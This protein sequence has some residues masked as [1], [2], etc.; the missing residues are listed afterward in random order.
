MTNIHDQ[1][2]I[3]SLGHTYGMPIHVFVVQISSAPA[4]PSQ[5]TV[6]KTQVNL[7][8]QWLHGHLYLSYRYSFYP[9]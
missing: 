4:E 3:Y 6:D 9:H 8:S 2:S 1:V 5:S 7:I